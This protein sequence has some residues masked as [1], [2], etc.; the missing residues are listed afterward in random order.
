MSWIATLIVNKVALSKRNLE[1]AGYVSNP[2][3]DGSLSAYRVH[4]L[5][6]TSLTVAAVEEIED[7]STRDAGG[8]KACSRS[9]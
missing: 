5:P 2:L 8:R 3:E 4:R 7:A 1:K 9:A 6:M